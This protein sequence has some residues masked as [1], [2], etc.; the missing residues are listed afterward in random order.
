[1]LVCCDRLGSYPQVMS[2]LKTPDNA[3]FQAEIDLFA[4]FIFQGPYSFSEMLID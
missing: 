1:M 3:V 4:V 2:G